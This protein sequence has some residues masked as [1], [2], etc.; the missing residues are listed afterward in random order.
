MKKFFLLI[1]TGSICTSLLQAQS[2]EGKPTLKDP[3]TDNSVKQASLFGITFSGYVNTDIF[4]DTRQTVVARDGQ[5][6]FYPD[7]V[8]LDPEGK[9]I[10]ARGT[11][12]I[13]SIQ[14]RI[15]GNIT[16]PDI[17]NAKTSGLIEGEF[18]GN[19]NAS[20]NTFRLRHAFVKLNWTK[21][22]LL[23]GQYWHPL[24]VAACFPEVVSLNTGAPFLVF[25][26]NPQVRITQQLGKF[27][28]L[29]AA[30]SQLDATS[31]G[32]DGPSSKY[33]R[34]SV[35][36][37][38]AFQFQYS[39]KNEVN[40]TEFLIGAS[41]DFLTLTPRLETDVVTKPAYD[42]V[43]NNLIVHHD[44]V[45]V[46]Y[47]TNSQATSL[48]AN[49]FAKLKLAKVTMKIG[50][51]YGGDCYAM[52]LI[53]GYAV[54]SVTNPEKGI[55]DYTNINTASAWADLK[56]NGTTWQTGIYGGFSKNLGADPDNIDVKKMYSRGAN[57]D[58]LYRVAPRFVL[59]VKKI[60]IASELDYTVA[61]YGIT[62][63]KG[64]VS[65]SQEV[66]NLR[67]LLGV[68]YYF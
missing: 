17:F 49:F 55:V 46:N 53:G 26:R 47:K 58:Y 42:T 68:Y 32:P 44:A 35:V 23:F 4:F 45:I 6:L 1:I 56:T 50:G 2:I 31:T 27:K 52:N 65:D 62:T 54:K 43:I 20:I 9:D 60:K 36:P 51:V 41:L 64:L 67:I 39:S 34:N 13:L 37:E 28:L 29:L 59:T 14:T 16:G 33:L 11:Y 3:K 21:T 48:I 5:W 10:N 63:G 66:V 30:I 57:I 24:F 8:R 18:Y 25:S 19:A 22:E 7:C 40:K 38:L 61:A 12:N 15:S